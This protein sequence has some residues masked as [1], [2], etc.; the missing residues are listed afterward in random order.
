MG[1]LLTPC[2]S[3]AGVTLIGVALCAGVLSLW[4]GYAELARRGDSAAAAVE[5][6]LRD[7][8][9][10]AAGATPGV[11]PG[12]LDIDPDVLAAVVSDAAGRP[13]YVF[14][15]E[16]GAHA[17]EDTVRMLEHRPIGWGSHRVVVEH[18]FAHAGGQGM[19]VAIAYDT[20]TAWHR[21]LIELAL[22]S[23]GALAALA[24]AI[25]ALRLVLARQLK[26]MR[27][28]ALVTARLADEHYQATIPGLDRDDEIGTMA[29]AVAS[30]KARLVDRE[31][32]RQLAAIETRHFSER[33]ARIDERVDSF[34]RSIGRSLHEV[35]G[36]SDQ[37]QV[38]ADSLASIAKQTTARAE[39][40]VS[41]IRQTSANV[42]T[43]ANASEDLSASI[44]EIE[45]QVGQT[46]SIVSA[47]TRSTAETSS[48]IKGLFTKSEKIDEIIGLI[49]S[50]AAQT[51]LLSLN[52]TIEA[53]RAG[54]SGRG[55]AVVAQEVKSLADQTTRAS[56]HVADH[57]RAIQA[58]T[59]QA[60]DAIEAIDVTMAKAE[61]FSAII[62]VAVERQA[63]ATTAISRN[64]GDAA[65]AAGVAADSMKRLAAAIGETDQ[66]AAQVH[67]SATDVGLQAHDL[68]TTI[69]AFLTDTASLRDGRGTASL[70]A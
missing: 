4:L 68:A 24:M 22:T 52:A 32:L 38:A 39:R 60:V 56:Q 30:F 5:H 16:M 18:D 23:I 33:H 67:Q 31:R 62:A 48:V 13:L 7:V 50:I 29:R 19:R 42:S 10:P 36:L 61:Q 64:A 51:N 55:F 45:R 46:R 1:P 25:L 54:E 6:L 2:A 37:M 49:Q 11:V 34:R 44:R 26:P 3:I 57:V 8:D 17:D 28:L 12:N 47:A 40:A 65:K 27:Q 59:S 66:S 15:K 9:A 21:A 53:A 41:A 58:A 69:D 43:V 14:R 63:T 20:R 35:G 70:A